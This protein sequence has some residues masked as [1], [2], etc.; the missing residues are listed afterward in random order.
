MGVKYT[1]ETRQLAIS[2]YRDG[3]SC[4]QISKVISSAPSTI[5]AWLSKD[6]LTRPLKA[7]PWTS[8][9]IDVLFDL[10]PSSSKSDIIA[11]LPNH[12]WGSIKD[13]SLK[14]GLH[15]DIF[16]LTRKKCCLDFSVMDTEEKAYIVGLLAADGNVTKKPRG[17]L[18]MA[19]GLAEQDL[20]HLETLR[21]I[22]C[23][24][25]LLVR[26]KARKTSHQDFLSLRIYDTQLCKDL[27]L[28]GIVPRKAKILKPPKNFPQELVHHFIRGLFDGDGSFYL[29]KGTNYLYAAIDG[30][31]DMM[32]WVNAQFC[33]FYPN[34]SKVQKGHETYRV[35]YGCSTAK[36][37]AEYIYKDST[38]YLERK[39]KKAQ[40]FM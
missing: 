9:E 5:W 2:L 31:E 38:V 20:K 27:S 3:L 18:F 1:K 24:N 8:E 4:S 34:K 19:I 33:D 6:S 15:R 11:E 13:K 32:L 12:S 10:Y 37:F 23:P 35:R 7:E 28:W 36:K 25:A 14:L 40:E 39:Y 29:Q 17:N 22:L 16:H 30:T 21:S 26:Y